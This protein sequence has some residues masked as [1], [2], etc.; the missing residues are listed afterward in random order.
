MSADDKQILYAPPGLAHG[1]CVTSGEAE[2]AYMASDE[3]A[4][5][6]ESGI[7]W[8]D[9]KLGI[10]WPIKQ[11]LLSARDRNWPLLAD[12]EIVFE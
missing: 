11:P 1:F 2:I 4:P 5:E 12:M 9:P 3:Y 8:N 7:L 6:A 10:D